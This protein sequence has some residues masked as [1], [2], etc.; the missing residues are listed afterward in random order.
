MDIEESGSLRIDLLGSTLDLPPI[1][2]ILP[3][4]VT[5][6]AA[7]SLSAHVKVQERDLPGVEI[8]SQDYGNKAFFSTQDFTPAQLG[9]GH[10]KELAFVA[11]ILHYF[12]V[13]ENV[14]LNLRSDS[15][16]GG[17]LGGSSVLGI[18][19]Y[20][21]LARYTKKHFEPEQALQVVRDIESC[22]L[23]S[24]PAGYQDY[25]PVLYGGILGL[26]PHPGSVKVCQLY[27]EKSRQFLQQH[28]TLVNSKVSHH[29]GQNNWQV[30]KSFFDGD[31]TLRRRLE[32]IERLSRQAFEAL[33]GEDFSGFLSTMSQEGAERGE[34]FSDIVVPEVRQLH[35]SLRKEDDSIGLKVCGAGGGGC[36]LLLHS[37]DSRPLIE[38]EVAAA[39]MDILPL[40]IAAPISN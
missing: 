29:S 6:N 25:Y 17:G 37:T 20:R 23:V 40:Q 3:D 36:F 31:S 16:T 4:T 21:A 24:G 33:R 32:S 12:G 13:V 9:S 34:F 2:L 1:N 5:L 8:V 22:I 7:I 19:L 35:A 15:P 27:T 14:S 18:T 10:F 26:C 28:L 39:G 30:Y 38:R 11:R